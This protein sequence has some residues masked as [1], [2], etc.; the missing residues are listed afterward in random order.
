MDVLFI[1]ISEGHDDNGSE[2]PGTPA[3]APGECP[4]IRLAAKGDSVVPDVAVDC[5]CGY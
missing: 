2:L 1:Y 3:A 5:C 4:D